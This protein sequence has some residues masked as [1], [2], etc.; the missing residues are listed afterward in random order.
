MSTKNMY[1]DQ[2]I[3]H[4][5]F[6][7]K[8]NRSVG[9][10]IGIYIF[11]ALCSAMMVFPLFFAICNA[12]KPL[13]EVLKNPPTV[14][15]RNPTFDNFSDLLITMSQGWVP[16]SRYIWNTIFIT[17]TG[18]LGHVVLA[19]MAAYVLAKYRFPG[20]QLFFRVA[21]VALMFSGYVTGI[22]NYLIMCKLHM[23]DTYWSLILPA[24]GGSLG[25][26]L[27]KQFMDGFPMSLVEA[28][29]IDGAS[30]LLIFWKLVMP[31]VKPAWL[32]ISIFSIQNLWN[33]AQVQYIYTE[34]KKM[35][36][37]ALDQVALGGIART[38]QQNAVIVFT[39][40]VPIVFFIFSQSQIM[41]T[42]A[43]SGL[44]D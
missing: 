15:P 26:F 44:K 8:P 17:V 9:G 6:R 2:T 43:T 10:D 29:K 21:V 1:K 41:E 32:T 3:H 40:S 38:G 18:T 33:N 22:P 7:R 37:Y 34:S 31:N 19:S 27:M 30:E 12:L 39:M 13:D 20:G 35:L 42:M 23:V 16:L 28:A 25:L 5:K 4:Y 36:R 11:L 24:I 14:L